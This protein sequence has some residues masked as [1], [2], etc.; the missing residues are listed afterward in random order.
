MAKPTPREESTRLPPP[1]AR[2]AGPERG[3]RAEAL[4]LIFESA[5][6]DGE[7][8]RHGVLGSPRYGKTYHLQNVIE[9]AVAS[10]VVDIALIHDAKRAEPQY[11]GCV[12]ESLQD[13][14]DWPPGPDDSRVIVLH[15]LPTT[16]EPRVSVEDTAALGLAL[17]AG[18][19]RVAVLADELYHG[20]RGRQTWSGSSF[21]R[22]LREGSSQG[23][24]SGWTTQIP[25]SLPT[26]ACDLSETMALFNL[27]G[28]SAS[29]AVETFR[30]PPD[31]ERILGQLGRGEFILVTSA[32]GWNGRI[33]GPR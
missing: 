32:A 24:S 10:G 16:P 19:Q 6:R 22:I 9:Q 8:F 1:E 18:G 21:P 29:Y 17:A 23:V 2:R 14:L 27:Q 3:T 7:G 25:Q 4:T 30:L 20:M 15:P 33:Y 28:R 31:A 11:V 5:V 12:R 26:E 13:L